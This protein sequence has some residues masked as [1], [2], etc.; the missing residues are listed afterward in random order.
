MPTLVQ[1]SI[2]M[3]IEGRSKPG[4]PPG[5]LERASDIRVLRVSGQNDAHIVFACPR[6]GEAAQEVYQQGQLW[7]NRPDPDA[8]G[9]DLVGDVIVGLRHRDS[10]SDLFDSSLLVGIRALAGAIENGFSAIDIPSAI[11]RGPATVDQA[12]IDIARAFARSTPRP[13]TV[14]VAGTLDMVRDSTSAFAIRLDDG[15]EVAGVLLA[16]NV[17]EI[18]LLLG[19]RVVVEGTAVFRPSGNLLRIDARKVV[20]APSAPGIWSQLPRPR[21]TRFAQAELMRRQ[22]PRS[23]L[24]GILGKWPGEETDAEIAAILEEIS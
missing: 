8:T 24:A 11:E 16:G 7:S 21:S 18:A 22:G 19:T 2:R 17:R 10:D 3:R 23:G 15:A 6:L 13:Q 1:R 20:S 4:R 5:W 9:L 14:R 12:V